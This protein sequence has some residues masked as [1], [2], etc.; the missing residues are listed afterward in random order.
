MKSDNVSRH[1]RIKRILRSLCLL[2]L[3]LKK[4]R[5]DNGFFLSSA[6]A[7]SV[8]VNLIPF[9][10]LLLALVGTYLYNDQEVFNHISTYLRNTVPALDPEI[11]RHL[12]RVIQNR[13]VVGILGFTG[14]LWVSTWVFGSLRIALNIIFKAKKGRG[15]IRGFAVD[16]LM[17]LLAGTFLLVS[18][19]LSSAVGLLEV[20]DGCLPITIGPAIRW[21]LKYVISFLFAVGMFFLIYKIIP[22]RRVHLR[23]A[24][25]AA[26]FASFFWEVAKHLFSWYVTHLARYSFFYGSLSA[27]AIFV[28]WVYYSSIILL[29]GGEY[30][31][32]L[33][34]HRQ[35][36]AA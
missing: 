6:I 25:Q 15:T 27:L 23:P 9:I 8:L 29:I 16:V 11:M 30:T 22:N 3:A 33:E 12:S 14:L 5:E 19:I 34:E 10:M 4:F 17:I 21:I 20:Y 26:L 28:V 13:Q 18:M 32:L 36:P 31:Y 2:W 1:A 24:F 35:S 7:F